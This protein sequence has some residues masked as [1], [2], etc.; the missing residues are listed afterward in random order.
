[1]VKTILLDIDETILDFKACE[2]KALAAA[3]KDYG[4][5]A[6][7]EMLSSY[8][9]INDKMWKKLERKEI[10]RERLRI[11]RF[12]EFFSLYDISAD[13]ERFA[14]SYMTHLS[15]T[16]VFIKGA[17]NVLKQLRRKFNLYAVTNGYIQTQ[18]GRI[19]AA[20]LNKFFKDVFISEEI[21]NVK[22]EVAFFVKAT[23]KIPNF[24]KSTCVLVGDSLTSDI[25]G[26]VAFGIRTI[27]IS[28]GNPRPPEAAKPDFTIR[29]I[30]ELP[31]L[32]R[33]I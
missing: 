2:K 15:Q 10:T 24:D 12:A 13:P 14:D 11:E 33:L 23:A 7:D 19:E 32:I 29:K 31:E 21:G 18:R 16:G 26:G 6:T 27:W 17:R 22:P 28:G 30:T 8:S 20:G 1:M 5:F 4:V 3:L 25:K 9:L